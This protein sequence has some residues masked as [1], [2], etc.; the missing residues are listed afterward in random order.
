M[1]PNLYGYISKLSKSVDYL[2]QKWRDMV[3]WSQ[4]YLFLYHR[5]SL[6][7]MQDGN[8]LF[9]YANKHSFYFESMGSVWDDTPRS[10]GDSALS[11]IIHQ[12]LLLMAVSSGVDIWSKLMNSEWTSDLTY[13]F[14]MDLKKIWGKNTAAILWSNGTL[15]E[16]NMPYKEQQRE[17]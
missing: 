16:I 4:Y 5:T 9:G 1:S 2:L 13:P 6:I 11:Q 12:I 3:Y 7:P 10:M 15:N 8:C 17:S 14:D